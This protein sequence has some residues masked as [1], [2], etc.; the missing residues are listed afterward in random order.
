MDVFQ[1]PEFT[2]YSTHSCKCLRHTTLKRSPTTGVLCP[3]TARPQES[4][5]DNSRDISLDVTQR[6]VIQTSLVD[7][8][9]SDDGEDEMKGEIVKLSLIK[10]KERGSLN[11]SYSLSHISSNTVQKSRDKDMTPL[12]Y[13]VQFSSTP[14]QR[15]YDVEMTSVFHLTEFSTKP[16]RMAFQQTPT[17]CKLAL[18]K[19]TTL[20]CSAH[21]L[22]VMAQ[23]GFGAKRA[24]VNTKQTRLNFE[25]MRIKSQQTTGDKD[26]CLRRNLLQNRFLQDM[27]IR[28]GIQHG[29]GDMTEKQRTELKKTLNRAWKRRR[30]VEDDDDD[31]DDDDHFWDESP[32]KR[33][34]FNSCFFQRFNL[35]RV[36]KSRLEKFRSRRQATKTKRQQLQRPQSTTPMVLS[37]A[38]MVGDFAKCDDLNLAAKNSN[39][40]S[41][42]KTFIK[43]GV[44]FTRC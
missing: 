28:S 35:K 19:T 10:P 24:R 2:N 1:T 12:T 17:S 33:L 32:R 26:S 14:T 40:P 37:K 3:S 5:R 31:D 43:N 41:P 9:I 11:L 15:S 22:C 4:K 27:Q 8:S 18:S 36:I 29:E 21:A 7:Y 20:P 34:K 6:D 25:L 13:P 16:E 23:T 44:K 30:T 42:F 38:K 39:S